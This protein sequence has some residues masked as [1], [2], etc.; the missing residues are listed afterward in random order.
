M[1]CST[2][3]CLISVTTFK[4]FITTCTMSYLETHACTP[5]YPQLHYVITQRF[6]KIKV[7]IKKHWTL[8]K[9]VQRLKHYV[10]HRHI[11]LVGYKLL[12]VITIFSNMPL[13]NTI[14]IQN[15]HLKHLCNL[16]TLNYMRW[17]ESLLLFN[18][19]HE[20]EFSIEHTITLKLLKKVCRPFRF[21]KAW[22]ISLQSCVR[23]WYY[24]YAH[25][26][27]YAKNKYIK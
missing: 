2:K 4:T 17:Y 11:M 27:N 19:A 22:G 14:Y 12:N 25:K 21:H 13:F 18:H 5:C 20:F 15:I 7:T 23:R 24:F 6:K 16:G 1:D 26:K 10:C 8:E 3:L 9:M